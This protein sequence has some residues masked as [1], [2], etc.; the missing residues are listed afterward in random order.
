MKTLP[1]RLLALAAF[2]V[3]LT[4]SPGTARAAA[5]TP[6]NDFHPPFFGTPF[7]AQRTLLLP[8]GKYLLFYKTNSLT[9]QRTGAITRFL[10]TDALDPS[11]SFTHDYSSVSAAAPGANGKLYVAANKNLYGVP[12]PDEILRL[13]SDGSIDSTFHAAVAQSVDSAG[14]ILSG[15]VL[16]IV[17]QPDGKILLGGSFSSVAG[18]FR[19]G[20]ARLLSNGDL[21]SS[22][23]QLD[24]LGGNIWTMALQ[25]N[26]RILIGGDFQLIGPTQFPGVARLN[27]N[28]SLDSTFQ[29]TGFTL[30]SSPIRAVAIQ[31]DGKILIGG[32]L[33]VDDIGAPPGSPPHRRPLFRVGADG[34]PDT[35]FPQV[36]VAGE[37]ANTRDLVVQADGKI[38]AAISGSVYRF[39]IDGSLDNSFHNAAVQDT[40]FDPAGFPG[41][42]ITLNPLASGG[43]LVGGAF[44]DVDPAGATGTSHFG[45]V[46][47][48]ANGTVDS[49][50]TTSHKTGSA[51]SPS[52]FLRL[53]DGSTLIGFDT[54]PVPV[55]PALAFNIGRLLPTGSLDLNFTL[56]PFSNNFLG[57][58]FLASGCTPTSDGSLLVFGEKTDQSFHVGK[59]STQGL[60]QSGFADEPSLPVFET[61][62]SLPDG[63][64]LL[65]AGN[66][67]QATV[68]ATLTRLQSNGQL[69]GT[70]QVPESIRSKQVVRDFDGQ[71]R[72][73]YVGSRVLAV[74]PDGKIL[75]EYYD[76]ERNFHLVRLNSDG[77]LDNSFRG[78]YSP[79]VDPSQTFPVIFDPVM[80]QTL[81]P[82]DA[83]YSAGFAWLDA[84]V[85]FD[86]RIVLAGQFTEFLDRTTNNFVPAR[87]LVRLMPDGT[88][89]HTF[90]IGGGAQWTATTETPAFFPKV[91]NVVR[92]GDG[93][94]LITGTFDA[95]NG[96]S[97]PG[98]ASLNP[99]GSVDTSFVPPATRD[100]YGSGPAALQRQGDGTFLLS[101]PYSLPG[102]ATAPTLIHILDAPRVANI[103]TRVAVG[104]GDK[105]LIGGF[106]ITGNT[107]KKVLV[108][109][110]ASSLNVNGTPVPGRLLDPVLELHG[111]GVLVTN[112]D[113]RS[114]QEEEIIDSTV[115]P[116]DDRESALIAT[117]NPGTYTAVMHGKNSAT[118]IGL[119]EIY[120]LGNPNAVTGKQAS[121]GNIS[122]RGFVQTGDNVMIGG[123]FITGAQT[124]VIVR[125]I[126]PE[127]TGR[128]VPGALQDTIL[129]L[130][131]ANGL[132]A[133]NDDW[134][135][136]QEAEVIASTVPPNDNRESAIVASLNPGGYTAIVR[137]KAGTTG[138]ALV[139]VYALP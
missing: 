53:A 14:S 103:S 45:V 112:D 79:G 81:Q 50:F 97:A 134:R 75:F 138:V 65:G 124:N 121:I 129:E 107:P 33:S 25:T 55:D 2:F 135:S 32:R 42:T 34:S 41:V 83:A 108:R 119:V 102:E 57:G 58:G 28:G 100:K 84:H 61:V 20:I 125:A 93:R 67:P 44:T 80:H 132:V 91:E 43:F 82:P 106:I 64:V 89:D 86:G 13:N 21:D 60:A 104:D 30:A 27:A 109:A 1:S 122:T 62:T 40:S 92:Q 46:R 126:G 87:G 116:A 68:V 139:E 94:L 56:A 130:H 24:I 85:Q 29:P 76:L 9:D 99:N 95:F 133:S 115:P 51:K 7:P 71:I 23:S 136:T 39:N 22:F 110:I 47:L 74:Q 18:V 59:F 98:I 77:S 3:V 73:L 26:G 54:A 38:V 78:T 11:F 35:N 6:D 114:T 49:S 36:P 48:N 37:I 72:S 16:K 128:G 131:D 15:S 19:P 118:G 117:L 120:D 12:Q 88:I 70:F 96:V 52:S 17:V 66:N 5:L 127:L 63:K 10:A 101:G 137:G 123:F 113:W 90:A 8:D 105:V 31:S 4:L 69:D 111:T